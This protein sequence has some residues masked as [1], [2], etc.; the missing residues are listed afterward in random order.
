MSCCGQKRLQW[1]QK[2]RQAEPA[3]T[4]A[5]PTLTDPVEIKYNGI[6]SHLV[7]GRQTGYLYLFG[8][9]QPNLMVDGRDA[10]LLL[11]D[12]EMFS[13]VNRTADIYSSAPKA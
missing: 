2:V 13:L 10:V 5:E 7:K 3:P 8:E 4:L 6:K 11:Q 1:Q 12:A 9:K